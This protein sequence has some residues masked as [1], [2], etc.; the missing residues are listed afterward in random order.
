MSAR[1]NSVAPI[2]PVRELEPA[3]AHYAALGFRTRPYGHGTTYGYASRGDVDI[4]LVGVGDRHDPKT[5]ASSV[6]LFVDDA[7]AL[8]AEWS[9]AGV[10][11][12]LVAPQD[13]EW[14][15]R[16]GSHI[17]PDGNLLRF[18]SPLASGAAAAD[19]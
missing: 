14:G 18:G 3:L 6:F 10:P 19:A 5:T 12:R 8:F 13:T 17:D 1:L 11:G 2:L 15:Q 9:A 7:D 16:E 4:H